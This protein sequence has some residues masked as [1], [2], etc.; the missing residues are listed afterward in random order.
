MAK[1]KGKRNL[2]LHTVRID[3][4]KISISKFGAIEGW[5]LV[6]KILSVLGP[7][8][9]SIAKEDY[10]GAVSTIFEKCDADQLV[11]LLQQLTSVV[12]VDDKPTVFSEDF[13]NY[14]FTLQVCKAVLEY[15]FDDFFSPI[16][17]VISGFGKNKSQAME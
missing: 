8:V 13:K 1:K 3:G 2:E 5:K 17:E 16:K 6:H 7:S 12:L 4:K 15:N 10:E 14:M 9:A 11:A